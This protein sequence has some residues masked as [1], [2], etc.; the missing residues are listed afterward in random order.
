[1]LNKTFSSL[2]SSPVLPRTQPVDRLNFIYPCVTYSLCSLSK[3]ALVFMSSRSSFL[4]DRNVVWLC[5]LS[6]GSP[7][8]RWFIHRLVS[9]RSQN[10][11]TNRR[12]SLYRLERSVPRDDR[13][14]ASV[15]IARDLNQASHQV[16]I[17]T[18]EVRLN[19]ILHIFMHLTIRQL[20]RIGRIFTHTA[21]HTAPKVFLVVVLTSS[22]GIPLVKHLVCM[23]QSLQF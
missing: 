15:V 7:Y 14:I 3:S 2:C 17:Q 1:V 16:Q 8:A 21:V 18:L 6:L 20:L 12:S 23:M 11:S 10:S 13:K 4:L 19:N 5:Y 9:L 22:S